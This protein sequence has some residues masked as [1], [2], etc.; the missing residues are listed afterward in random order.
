M[1]TPKG[2]VVTP[3]GVVFRP[4]CLK[5]TFPAFLGPYSEIVLA[6]DK[7]LALLTHMQY[8]LHE[9]ARKNGP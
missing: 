2:V 9:L 3:K 5:T 7:L 8:I 6:V 1:G 4:K